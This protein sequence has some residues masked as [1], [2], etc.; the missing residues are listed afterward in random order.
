MDLSTFGHLVITLAYLWPMDF[1]EVF[2]YLIVIHIMIKNS[3]CLMDISL[4][5]CIINNFN[6]LNLSITVDALI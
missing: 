4:L 3:L 1:C 2:E 6:L 5:I